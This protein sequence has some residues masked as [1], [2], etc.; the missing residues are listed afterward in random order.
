MLTFARC[1]ASFAQSN[2]LTDEEIKKVRL[3]IL[4]NQE[5]DSLM[6]LAKYREK[7]LN[8]V[9]D[10]QNDI[11]IKQNDQMFLMKQKAQMLEQQYRYATKEAERQ[12]RRKKIFQGATI[13]GAASIGT[14]LILK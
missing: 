14:L 1:G 3:V 10:T 9:I 2:C 4:E 12:I 6:S 8:S 11:I 5:L 7:R 13:L